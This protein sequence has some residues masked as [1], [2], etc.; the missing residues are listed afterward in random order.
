MGYCITAWVTIEF[1]KD[2]SCGGKNRELGD[3]NR[4]KYKKKKG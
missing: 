2:P 1:V 4:G 3:K